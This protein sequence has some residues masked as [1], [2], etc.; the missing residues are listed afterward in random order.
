MQG[1]IR[2]IIPTDFHPRTVRTTTNIRESI[3]ILA[4]DETEII[5]DYSC[6]I[7]QIR[8]IL[9]HEEYRNFK[10]CTPDEILMLDRLKNYATKAPINENLPFEVEQYVK[11]YSK[12]NLQVSNI[13]GKVIKKM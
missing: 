4:H 9:N 8:A 12:G 10:D 3:N 6:L 1:S 13:K 11:R 2:T 5:D 7:C